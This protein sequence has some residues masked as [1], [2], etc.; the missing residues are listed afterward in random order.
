MDPKSLLSVGIIPAHAFLAQ[1]GIPDDR[2]SRVESLTIAGQESGWAYRVQNGG[3]AHSFWQFEKGGGVVGVM[4][5]PASREHLKALCGWLAIPFDADVIY[6]AMIYNDVLAA[7]MARLLL[8]TDPRPMPEID[9]VQGGWD[10]Y[11]RN[12]RPGAPHPEAWDARYATALA[13]VS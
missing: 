7:G 4:N 11:Q 3:P 12:W 10:T 9:D 1:R 13:A 8:L 5:H 2:K 6:Q